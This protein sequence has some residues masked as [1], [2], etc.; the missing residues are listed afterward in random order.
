M[1]CAYHSFAVTGTER[2]GDGA[3]EELGDQWSYPLGALRSGVVPCCFASLLLATGLSPIPNSSLT[4]FLLGNVIEG[5]GTYLFGSVRVG[6]GFGF[7][8]GRR[9]L[10]G[11][12]GGEKE[13]LSV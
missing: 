7:G 1:R 6:V 9:V 5:G 4:R 2:T 10:V 3:L 13:S 8:S 11:G 12:L